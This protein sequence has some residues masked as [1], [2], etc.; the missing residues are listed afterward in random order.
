MRLILE[1]HFYI[2]TSKN[3]MTQG[4]HVKNLPLSVPNTKTFLLL[5]LCI[6]QKTDARKDYT[7]NLAAFLFHEPK[8]KE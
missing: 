8:A 7:I 4:L 5:S 3:K 2:Q 6:V 1:T